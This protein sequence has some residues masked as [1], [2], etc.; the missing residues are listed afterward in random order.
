MKTQ[1]SFWCRLQCEGRLFWA[2]RQLTLIELTFYVSISE[3]VIS[4]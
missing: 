1:K 3:I 4:F 2:E